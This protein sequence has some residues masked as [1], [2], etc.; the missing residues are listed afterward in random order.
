MFIE[1]VEEAC[2]D[3]SFMGI[4]T[5]TLWMGG[6]VEGVQRYC[7]VRQVTDRKGRYRHGLSA[8]EYSGK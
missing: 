7:S 2:S 4:D 8:L 3:K 1:L 6:Y 5:Q